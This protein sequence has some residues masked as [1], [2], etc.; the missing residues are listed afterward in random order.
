[1]SSR[2]LSPPDASG[3]RSTR[4][5]HP[6]GYFSRG[7]ASRPHSSSGDAIRSRKNSAA[8]VVETVTRHVVDGRLRNASPLGPPNRLTPTP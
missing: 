6:Y 3:V 1:M 8:A 5:R 7:M 2:P 4:A